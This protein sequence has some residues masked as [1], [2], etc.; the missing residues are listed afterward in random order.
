MAEDPQIVS[1]CGCYLDADSKIFLCSDH[2]AFLKISDRLLRTPQSDINCISTDISIGVEVTGTHVINMTLVGDEKL[3]PDVRVII[4]KFSD[5][6]DGQEGIILWRHRYGWK[7]KLADGNVVE[8][9]EEELVVITDTTA[10]PLAPED[11]W[12]L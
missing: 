6:Y 11:T 9:N 1:P 4:T 10:P 5:P 8:Y 12:G 3:G 2:S 7:V